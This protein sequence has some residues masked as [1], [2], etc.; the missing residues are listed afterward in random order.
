MNLT[1]KTITV[2]EI[3]G[4]T[5]QGEGNLIGRPTLFV[6]TGGCDFR[7]RWCDSMH[8]VDERKFGA[9]W[10]EMDTQDVLD[11]LL[12]LA[13][14]FPALVTVS[15]GNPAMQPLG[16]L[17][18]KGQEFGFE[19]AMETQGSLARDWFVDLDYL[20]LSPKPPSSLMPFRM[21]KL[22]EC[23]AAARFKDRVEVDFPPEIVM[24]VVVFDEEDYQFARNIG[25][26]F[27]EQPLYLSVGTDQE[28]DGRNRVYGEL[29]KR[30]AVEGIL[31]RTRWLVERVVADRWTDVTVLPQL[32]VLLW[33]DERGR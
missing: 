8:A 31:T 6:R 24:K 33:G 1:K 22:V 26:Q 7:C 28:H 3:F 27:P 2:S 17:I 15:G 32:H 9:D 29:G 13:G 20:V 25:R 19:F 5:I 14:G 16:E 18:R 11:R 21:E 30:L 10:D 4:P 23:V 12:D